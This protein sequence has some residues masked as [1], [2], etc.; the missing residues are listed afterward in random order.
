MSVSGDRWR[1]D[2]A[3]RVRQVP[4]ADHDAQSSIPITLAFQKALIGR[5][6]PAFN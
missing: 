3:T 1:L 6:M 2:A 5:T 4:S